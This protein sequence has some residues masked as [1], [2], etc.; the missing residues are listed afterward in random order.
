[1]NK[2]KIIYWIVLSFFQYEKKNFSKFI[3]IKFIYFFVKLLKYNLKK[4]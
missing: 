1:M 2:K 4:F 3:I